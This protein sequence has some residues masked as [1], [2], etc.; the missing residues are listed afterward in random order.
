M[1]PI[2]SRSLTLISI[3][4]GLFGLYLFLTFPNDTTMKLLS[5]LILAGALAIRTRVTAAS[6]QK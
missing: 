4:I 6:K 2:V 3:A 5:I 1:P